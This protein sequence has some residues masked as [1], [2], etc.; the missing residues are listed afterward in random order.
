MHA[1]T[2]NAISDKYQDMTSRSVAQPD[3]LDKP[4]W[5]RRL[6]ESIKNR[7]IC[8]NDMVCP[9]LRLGFTSMNIVSITQ[10]TLAGLSDL[11]AQLIR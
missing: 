7:P 5:H 2:K 4:D 8:G 1:P 11:I 9:G 3:P 10:T 6:A